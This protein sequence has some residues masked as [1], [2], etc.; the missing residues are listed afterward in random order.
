MALS[1]WLPAE[2]APSNL[3]GEPPKTIPEQ[4]ASFFSQLT[5]G[6]ISPLLTVGYTRP[7]EKDDLW[8][9][10]ESKN[11]SPAADSFAFTYERIRLRAQLKQEAVL[12]KKKANTDVEGNTSEAPASSEDNASPG[13]LFRALFV[14]NFW[15]W[16][17]GGILKLISGALSVSSPLLTKVFIT[18]LQDAYI[19]AHMPSSGPKPSLLYGAGLAVALASMQFL[20][21]V[22]GTQAER[23]L[24]NTQIMTMSA[25]NANLFRKS[26]RL[27]PRARV[28]HSKGE[29]TNLFSEDAEKAAHILDVIHGLYVAPVQFAI[30]LTLLIHLL[31]TSGLI[32]MAV[33]LGS[34]PVQ[35]ILLW[36]LISSI[37]KSMKIADDRV[38]VMQEVLQGIRSI[39]VYAWEDFFLNR[40]TGIRQQ[41]L[42]YLQAFA[43]RL[44]WLT[45]VMSILPVASATGAFVHYSLSGHLLTPA[46]VFSGLQVFNYLRDIPSAG[47]P[48]SSLQIFNAE[49]NATRFDI[50][51]TAS[52]GLSIENASFTWEE[53][54]KSGA[55]G[56]SQ[57]KE[58]PAGVV[59]PPS[60]KSAPAILDDVPPQP[61][62]IEVHEA[63]VS[64]TTS[65]RTLRSD[66]PT[67]SNK[68][69]TLNKINISVRR[70][71]F[72]AVVGTVASGKTSLLEAVVGDMRKVGGS[73]T[74]GGSL[75]YAP[76]KPWILNANVKDNI[77]FGN[78][79]DEARYK[80]CISA[81]ALTHDLS[82]LSDGDKTEIGEKGINLSG[83]Q[84][85]RVSLARVAY[86]DADVVLLDDPLSAVD[87]GVGK[88]ILT[89]CL[90]NGPLSTRTRVLATH[91][92]HV[93][94]FVDVIYVLAEGRVIE[95][96]TY[97]ELKSGAGAFA[98]LVAQHGTSFSEIDEEAASAKVDT[99]LETADEK[100]T[101][102]PTSLTA[103]EDRDVGSVPFSVY[104]WFFSLSGSALWLPFLLVLATAARAMQIASQYF[105][106]FWSSYRFSGWTNID[107]IKVY[108]SLGVGVAL[109]GSITSFAFAVV[110]LRANRSLFTIALD[111]VMHSPV[112]FFDTVPLGRIVSRLTKDVKTIDMSIGAQF[113]QIVNTF[114]F[115]VTTLGIVFF[116]FPPLVFI[117]MPLGL[118]YA[119]CF[120]FYRQSSVEIRRVESIVR[121][122][123]FNSYVETLDGLST[124]RA[125]NREAYFIQRTEDAIDL[126]N[127]AVYLST[128]MAMWLEFRLSAVGTLIAL[129]VA[130]FSVY[131]AAN[132]NPA[133]SAI[134]MNYVLSLTGLLS[135]AVAYLATLEQ[136][137]SS[138]Q[139][140]QA[141]AALPVE[142][143]GKTLHAAPPIWPDQ[144]AIEFKNI[145]LT[146]RPGLPMVLQDVS[147]S[148]KPGEKVGVCGRTGAGKSS[149]IQALF[150][151][152]EYQRGSII[153]D[154]Q[155]TSLLELESLRSKLGIIPQESVFLGTVRE[156]IDPLNTCTDAELL[157][158]LR[159]AHLE[160]QNTGKFD[161]NASVGA[162]GSGLSA[163]EKQQLQICRVLV[164]KSKVVVLDEATSSVDLETDAKLQQTIRTQ[165]AAATLLVIAH[166]LNTILPFDKV[167]VMDKGRVAE[168]DSPLRLYDAKGIFHDLCNEAS[169]SREDIV[170]IQQ[171]S[172][173][174]E[175][176]ALIDI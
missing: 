91:A 21:T 86:S 137:M 127:R 118:L 131:Q 18:Y 169:I 80:D 3:A 68:P 12:A 141:Y 165:L 11:A 116:Q 148:I 53:Q 130:L 24:L 108:A 52:F 143:E 25:L 145:D 133:D 135:S 166:R 46:I 51:D 60:G 162:D 14:L 13:V 10:P 158:I 19:N 96:G 76:Q 100:P 123:T 93:L 77:L 107:Y 29:I 66:T 61:L 43:L 7:I 174:S 149:L 134:V 74:L 73:V 88:H 115:V 84:K 94:P 79:L 54:L 156:S 110:G 64:D 104:S 139:R 36:M 30:G 82:T 15:R 5:F 126:H 164:K 65:G 45:A 160:D 150:R 49:E 120:V 121:S 70:G 16:L 176:P 172:G 129:A 4:P 144:G 168:F 161:L 42:S 105:L 101:A 103:P 37:T 8:S 67:P 63:T 9:L 48:R 111:H 92:L 136:D 78:E 72:V 122:S 6:W 117:V 27:S 98:Q 38:K 154:G 71:N 153:I 28:V 119:A 140:L 155:D 32:G 157:E 55:D 125:T 47:Q 62:L 163:G 39:K 87:A 89:N 167:L 151:T 173:S 44:S 171:T 109:T 75:A 113:V 106:G 159:Q 90:L 50:D 31:G 2:P 114:L 40:V 128:V 170:K 112:T 56:Q 146:Y 142:G 41:E 57:S 81:C 95:Q 1:W 85:A 34:F 69:F 59:T 33:V 124:V 102:A 99:V 132:V 58:G 97:K 23:L 35:A 26:L 152:F 22:I 175:H 17:F 147:F 20:S 83:G 138:V